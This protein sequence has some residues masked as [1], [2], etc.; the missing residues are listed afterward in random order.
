VQTFQTWKAWIIRS[1]SKASGVAQRMWLQAALDLLPSSS[2]KYAGNMAFRVETSAEA[3]LD[4]ISIL[5]FLTDF[6][7]AVHSHPKAPVSP[8]KWGRRSCR[9]PPAL[10]MRLQPR[11]F[12]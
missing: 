9:L 10:D 7:N 8:L 2:L 11:L 4:A 6:R 5:N 1:R 12:E 3:E